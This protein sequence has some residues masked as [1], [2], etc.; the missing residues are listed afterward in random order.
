MPKVVLYIAIS[1]DGYIADKT[2]GVA[3]LEAMG[4]P[5]EDFGYEAF[6]ATIGTVIMGA[7]TYEQVLTFPIDYPYTAHKSYII[8]HRELA[9]PPIPAAI[10][11]YQGDLAALVGRIKNES[12]KDIWL[13]GGGV[14]NAQFMAAGLIDEYQM[15]LMP[16]AL[17]EGLALFPG[18]PQHTRLR[19]K[20][21]KVYPNGALSLTYGRAEA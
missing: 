11:F 18:L 12:Q 4:E 6:L 17:G 10:E 14:L 1:L 3:W 19:L 15:T 20:S 16:I 7:K 13:V 9:R 2:G 5:G 8:T 21:H